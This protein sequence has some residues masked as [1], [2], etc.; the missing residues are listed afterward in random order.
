MHSGGYGCPVAFDAVFAGIAAVIIETFAPG[1][2]DTFVGADHVLCDVAVVA[3]DSSRTIEIDDVLLLAIASS[4][5]Q[6]LASPFYYNQLL[7]NQETVPFAVVID[8]Y[9]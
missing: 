5:V 1:R 8:Y 7:W 2:Q 6:M 9:R 3:S 4:T